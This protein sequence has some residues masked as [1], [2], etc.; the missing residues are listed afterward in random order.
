MESIPINGL[1]DQFTGFLNLLGGNGQ[2]RS[3]A[4]AIVTE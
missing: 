2:W 4:H 3:D 1:E